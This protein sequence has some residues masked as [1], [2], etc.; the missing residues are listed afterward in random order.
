MQQIKFRHIGHDK[1][2]ELIEKRR[3][4]HSALKPHEIPSPHTVAYLASMNSNW[5]WVKYLQAQNNIYTTSAQRLRRCPT[6]YKC[7]TNMCVYWDMFQQY[8]DVAGVWL[9]MIQSLDQLYWWQIGSEKKYKPAVRN[10]SRNFNYKLS[11]W[12]FAGGG[13]WNRHQPRVIQIPWHYLVNY[14]LKR[15]RPK[16][17]FQFEIIIKI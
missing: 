3:E 12:L 13:Y 2:L 8:T 6:L 9:W 16:D 17:F 1:R 11:I 7:Y 15:W 14:P 5:R 4:Y 10:L